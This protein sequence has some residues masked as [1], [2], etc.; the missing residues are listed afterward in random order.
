MKRKLLLIFLFLVAVAGAVVFYWLRMGG[1]EDAEAWV[2]RQLQQIASAYLNPTL[3]FDKLTYNYPRTVVI[4]NFRLTDRDPDDPDLSIDIFTVDQLT[5]ELGEI[6]KS[7]EPIV[8]ERF[9]LTNPKIRLVPT[10]NGA[11]VLGYSNL[12]RD[13]ALKGDAAPIPDDEAGRSVRASDVFKIRLIYV[14]NGAL[15]YDARFIDQPDMLLDELSFVLRVDPDA[16]GIY[17]IST[18]IDRSPLLTGVVRGKLDLDNLMLD[19]ASLNVDIGLA[20]EQYGALPPSLQTELERYSVRG[21]L[22]LAASGVLDV[23]DFP[24][25]EL[26]AD[27]AMAVASVTVDGYR[28]TLKDFQAQAALA[29]RRVTVTELVFDTL[30]GSVKADG[31][32]ELN[33]VYDLHSANLTATGLSLERTRVDYDPEKVEEAPLRGQLDLLVRD[34]GGP[35][36]DIERQASGEG[37]LSIS[38]A[39]LHRIKV[40]DRIKGMF[41]KVGIGNGD[42]QKTGKDTIN[43]DFELAGDHF[44]LA[45][46]DIHSTWYALTGN[47]TL[48]FDGMVDLVFTGGPLKKIENSMGGLGAILSPVNDRLARYFVTGTVE[49]PEVKVSVLGVNVTQ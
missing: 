43:I 28:Y 7:G 31:V 36:T 42:T 23:Q 16:D 8:L 25:S 21:S 48:D 46:I 26:S 40:V 49:D 29:D 18:T 32:I 3:T 12:L 10:G 22:K 20:P 30:G 2:G 14:E 41:G 39:K 33:D 34:A 13:S 5:L 35:L 47:G 15:A 17:D 45:N 19:I 27:A 1:K 9:T 38:Q 4:D 11:E 24:G 44:N 6:P 37:T